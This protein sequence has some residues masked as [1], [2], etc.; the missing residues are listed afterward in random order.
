MITPIR[1]TLVLY[2]L[3]LFLPASAAAQ[4]FPS[5][6]DLIALI[7][8][9]V[10]ENQA[11][12]MVLG[13]M[14][15]DG[16]TRIVSYGNAG[17]NARALGERSVFEIGSIT[18][19]FTG[20]L[21]ADMVAR[22]EVSLSDPV[23]DYLPDGVTMPSRSGRE[24][25]LLD[26]STHR[27]ALPRM[28][29]NMPLGDGSNSYPEYT[30]EQLYAFL[31]EHELR[32]DIGSE[33]EYSNIAVALLGHVLARVGGGS[34]REV[35]RER[36]L[37][38]LGMTMT[39]V[40][41]EGELRDWMT[42]GHDSRGM[43][44]PY[45]NWPNLPGMGA[46]RS[47][48]GDLLTFLA[49]NTGAPQSALERAMRDAHEVRQSANPEADVGLNWL[50][51]KVGT[52]RIV[53]HGGG[54]AGFSTFVGFD[55]E[56]GVGTVVLAN[57]RLRVSD[58]GMHLINPDV[59]LRLTPTPEQIAD[60]TEV[61]VAED[62]LESYVGDYELSATASILVTLEDGTLFA[63]PAGDDRVR[64]AAESETK[65]FLTGVDAQ[66][67][68]TKDAAGAVTGLILHQNG[69]ERPAPRR[70]TPG[71]PLASADGGEP[72]L[73]GLRIS[74]PS[75]VLGADRALRILT[76]TGYSLSSSSR[77]PVLYVIDGERPLQHAGGVMQSL[78]IG[79]SM[80]QMIIVHV[81]DVPIAEGGSDFLTFLTNELQPWVESEYRAAPFRV[82]AGESNA[83]L[84]AAHVFLAAP[85]AF[86]AYVS[87]RPGLSERDEGFEGRVASIFEDRPN[88]KGALYLTTGSDNG[89]VPSGARSL[90]SA[91]ETYA[92]ASLRWEW[93][94]VDRNS[95]PHS[96]LRNG[97]EWLF[98]GWE[99]P[100]IAAL[101]VQE[102]GEGW[103]V[104]DAHYAELSERFGYRVV[105]H[106]D[107]ADQAG[108][109]FARQGRFD[110]AI[111]MLERNAELHPGSAR[112]FN[113][114]GDLYRIL[115]RREESKEN[116][117]K[118]FEMARDMSYSNVSNYEREL[119]RITTEIESG[120]E[121]TRPGS[122]RAEV[123]VAEEILQTYVGE[124]ALSSTFS[125]V[126]TLED[127][128]LFAQPGGQGKF[129]IFADSETT[130]FLK[131]VD[132]QISFTKDDTGAVTGMILHQ[133]GRD[134]PG[135]RVND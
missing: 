42:Q 83:G 89:A 52:A 117:S 73:P 125:I 18:K 39:D 96:S 31:S 33:Y 6:E 51:R 3:A 94:T 126:V 35:L 14:E 13:V 15:A 20:T 118:A 107:L 111:R 123:E 108:F 102:G 81:G 127:G 128:A 69:R 80:P 99:L 109:A 9:R 32:R 97:F 75:A 41:V 119:N 70:T 21:L 88:L 124:Y 45:R 120:R 66:I 79:E 133:N 61:E 30:I 36:I 50:I 64:L 129:R 92:P 53:M 132:A 43:V 10:E 59:P 58:I 100:D 98:D 29:G 112:V 104:I 113:H 54:T 95:D 122:D 105:P 71:V 1:R 74:V 55:P 57:A 77:Y 2:A 47:N 27:S 84:F 91:V 8:S 46:L 110:D 12:G 101:A 103:L 4:H 121:C 67:S 76:P 131:A 56:T 106:E 24:I 85:E 22:G 90:T 114:L 82:L 68:F 40:T 62:I 49:A 5:N 44:A 72:S 38:P 115:C 93:S 116:Y 19:V 63:Q 34:Y 28:P 130:F 60:R 65:F 7:R 17:P 37:D 11:G 86:Q 25:T 48:V 16:T 23:S 134:A 135:R 87:I 26:L 78:V